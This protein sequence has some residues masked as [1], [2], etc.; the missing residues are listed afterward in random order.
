LGGLEVAWVNRPT[1]SPLQCGATVPL[2][3]AGALTAQIKKFAEF[4]FVRSILS[5]NLK[6]IAA[7]KLLA[8]HTGN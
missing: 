1:F 2:S 7:L 6:R 5:E 3:Y 8:H 4:F